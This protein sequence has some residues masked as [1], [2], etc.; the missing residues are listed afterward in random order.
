[1][2]NRRYKPH[3]S[4]HGLQ[5]AFVP[6]LYHGLYVVP[7]ALNPGDPSKFAYWQ[8]ASKTTPVW[9]IHDR[10][11][12]VDFDDGS[13]PY[14]EWSNQRPGTAMWTVASP[15]AM[16]CGTRMAFITTLGRSQPGSGA[17]VFGWCSGG[18]SEWTCGL[19]S[20]INPLMDCRWSNNS[21]GS[22]GLGDSEWHMI[23]LA[24]YRHSSDNQ[25]H[26]QDGL[27]SHK[28]TKA[29]GHYFN[30]DDKKLKLGSSGD[31][32]REFKGL[33]GCCYE[34]WNRTLE[35]REIA[36]IWDDYLAPVRHMLERRQIVT[37]PAAGTAIEPT[38]IASA[39][40]FGSPSIGGRVEASSITSAEAH[41]SHSIG[42]TIAATGIVSGEQWALSPARLN[43]TVACSSITSDEAFGTASVVGTTIFAT[44]ITSAEAFGATQFDGAIACVGIA[45]AESIGSH[46]VEAVLPGTISPTGIESAEA[47][48]TASLV[49]TTI[50][51][52]SIT[53]DEAFGGASL[54]GAVAPSGIAS[55]EQ[56]ALSPAYIGGTIVATAIASAE[57]F[58]SHVITG[59]G[60]IT[61]TAGIATAEAFGTPAVYDP[62]SLITPAHRDGLCLVSATQI[63]RVLA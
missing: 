59:D 63:A 43:G 6:D 21:F 62:A 30:S 11:W 61:M 47:F 51:V 36:D 1:M 15:Y 35:M 60:T 34:W 26:Y 46:A 39:E 9:T 45:S 33:A 57:A 50:I 10:R 49:G 28:H 13:G 24:T 25:W 44:G 38:G 41:G 2:S 3:S 23:A 32:S 20:G 53:S 54:S 56:W 40:A 42:G 29:T 31:S 52:S 37:V 17:R 19:T 12:C 58:G 55:G 5:F 18:S 22:V 16:W 4:S 7:D 14:F 27:L 8:P 48:G